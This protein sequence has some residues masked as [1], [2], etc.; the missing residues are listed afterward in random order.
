MAEEAARI[1]ALRARLLER[2]R[3]AIPGH[4]G[5]RQHGRAHRRQPQPDLPGRHRR[6]PDGARA[7][8]S[9]SP[10]APPARRRRSS[11]PM[12]CARSACPTRRPR[13]PCASGSDALP[14]RPISTT[15][16]RRWP[17]RMR[18]CPPA[19]SGSPRPER[20]LPPDAEDDVH[21]ARRHAPRSRCAARPVGAGDRAQARRRY[22]GRL[23]GLAR[24]LDLPRHRGS[25]P[26]SAS[27]P[28]R[29]RTRRTCS[30]WR[31]A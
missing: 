15:R 8:I 18:G 31:S 27:W 4:R 11:R 23:R 26:G 9:A 30:T 2:L 13:A 16:P 12:C 29:P 6:R 19:S 20:N 21:R 17:R 10:P 1:A 25:R 14:R 5:Q 24:L 22:R 3:A 7:R 28:S